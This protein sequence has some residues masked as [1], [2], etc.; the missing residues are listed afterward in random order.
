MTKR[1][2]SRERY[3]A[4]FLFGTAVRKREASVATCLVAT[5]LV[6]YTHCF[7]RTSLFFILLITAHPY[8][9]GRVNRWESF[10]INKIILRL[11]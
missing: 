7:Y 3:D 1:W 10:P 5:C 4:D 6:Y 8:S 2:K 11:I 9:T